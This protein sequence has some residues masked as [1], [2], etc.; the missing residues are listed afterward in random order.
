M[1]ALLLI[2]TAITIF[3]GM[4]LLFSIIG[5]LWIP[6]YQKII[7][8]P[9]WFIMY[10]IFIGWWVTAIPIMEIEE[11]YSKKTIIK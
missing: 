11:V 3:M 1:K 6:S 5:L 10:C 2:I 9:E 7:S 4:F 8:S